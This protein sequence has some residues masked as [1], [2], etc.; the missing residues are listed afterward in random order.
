MDK[1]AT[2]VVQLGEP[3]L[4]NPRSPATLGYY[5]YSGAQPEIET[6]PAIRGHQRYYAELAFRWLARR[7]RWA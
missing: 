6:S 4:H 1:L 3:T 2:T 7:Q 5:R